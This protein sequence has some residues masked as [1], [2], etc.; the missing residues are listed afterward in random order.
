M[1][2]T[3]KQSFVSGPKGGKLSRA[4]RPKGAANKTT[5]SVKEAI[6]LAADRLG[7]VDRLVAWCQ[8]DP[9][10]EH[11]FWSSVYPKLLPLQL[12]GDED[13]PIQAKL[14]VEFVKPDAGAVS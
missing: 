9:K 3:T 8:E 1:S 12:A 13:N 7:G 4:G 2:E 11:S 5:R 10:N 14:I 6:A